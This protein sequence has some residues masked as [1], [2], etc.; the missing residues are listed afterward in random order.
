[1]R[2]DNLNVVIDLKAILGI[3]SAGMHALLDASAVHPVRTTTG[4]SGAESYGAY[5][6]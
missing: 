4:V 1:M 6:S 5:A 3:D 2:E